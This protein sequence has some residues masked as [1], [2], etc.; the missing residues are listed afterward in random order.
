MLCGGAGSRTNAL[1]PGNRG[2][3]AR[4]LATRQPEQTKPFDRERSRAE[5]FA[6]SKLSGAAAGE[7]SSRHQA[8]SIRQL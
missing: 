8:R 7:V 5:R 1:A 3:G 2:S 4:D 6:S